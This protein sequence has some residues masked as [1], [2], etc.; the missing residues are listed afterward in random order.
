PRIRE[1]PA[2]TIDQIAAGAILER[3]APLLKELLENSLDAGAKVLGID[4]WNGGR[5]LRIRDDGHGILSEDLP[6]AVKRFAT[7]KLRDFEDLLSVR[8][9][10]F[11]GEALASLLSVSRLSIRSRPQLQEKGLELRGEFGEIQEIREIEMSPGTEIEV[12]DLFQNVP[13]RLK[14]LK[15][16]VSEL[17]QIKSVLKALALARPEIHLILRIEGDLSESY[18][19]SSAL[20]RVRTVLKSEL[21]FHVHSESEFWRGDFYFSAPELRQRT[22]KNMWF[23]VNSRWVQDRSLQAAVLDAYRNFLM[24]GDFPSVAVFIQASAGS[25][26]F[27]VHPQKNQIKFQDSSGVFRWV[28]NSL[29]NEI[30]KAPWNQRGGYRDFQPILSN[31]R[32]D[33][34][35]KVSQVLA[36][37]SLALADSQVPVS[38]IREPV[39]PDFPNQF[40]YHR[41]AD[42]SSF[43]ASAP[44]F[45]NKFGSDSI[46]NENP[47]ARGYWSSR[48]LI[49][50]A[51]LTYLVCQDPEGLLLI[52]QHAAHER[53]LFESWVQA[54]SQGKIQVQ[55][56]LIPLVLDLSAEKIEVLLQQKH[57]LDQAGIEVEALGPTS[58]GVL[59]APELMRDSALGQSLEKMAEALLEKSGSNCVEEKLRE[60]F[61]SLAC[62]SAIRAGQSLSRLEMQALLRQMDEH[63]TSSHCPHGR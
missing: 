50:Q 21:I 26:D 18:S 8:S 29:L 24:H 30:E 20:Q 31:S 40:H 38:G 33:Q 59:S 35:S 27:N 47:S 2:Q 53:I 56:F 61:A 10:G 46:A 36:K 25:V 57:S 52:D 51:N 62:H 11:R 44:A 45:L 7:S 28:R 19:P 32:L 5:E 55:R 13:A 37:D 3:P 48:D 41:K 6:L 16:E 1:L 43:L 15:S 9:F 34:E 58:L 42:E 49:G 12:R 39:L 23:F 63:P 17:A 22:S 14:F 60:L 54:F 4:V